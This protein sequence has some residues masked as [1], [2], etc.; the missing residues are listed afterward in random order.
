MEK[1]VWQGTFEEAEAREIALYAA[2]GWKESAAIVEDLRKAIW[3][4]AYK[5][6]WCGL[7]NCQN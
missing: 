5:E 1:I 2:A 6:K 4:K 7:C 3:N